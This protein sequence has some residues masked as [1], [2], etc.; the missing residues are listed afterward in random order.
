MAIGTDKFLLVYFE[1][2]LF[3]VTP[4]KAD[5]TVA[6][7][8]TIATTV[9]ITTSAA[10]NINVGDIVLFDQFFTKWHRILSIRF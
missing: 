9:T 6:T 2:Q 4:L 1:G 5:I 3:D 8:S 10:H 7:L